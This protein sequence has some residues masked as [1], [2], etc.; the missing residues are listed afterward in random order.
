MSTHIKLLQPRSKYHSLLHRNGANTAKLTNNESPE[1]SNEGGTRPIVDI[2]T[3]FTKHDVTKGKLEYK[4]VHTTLLPTA[5]VTLKSNSGRLIKVRALL[6]QGSQSTFISEKCAQYLKAKRTRLSISV[7]GIGGNSV[8][9]VRS[10]VSFTLVPCDQSKP[11][12]PLSALVLPKLTY[13]PKASYIKNTWPHL[14]N[15]HLAD[16]DFLARYPLSYLLELTFTG[17][18]L[19]LLNRVRHGPD[20]SPTAQLT[21]FGWIISGS[22]TRTAETASLSLVESLDESLRK[23]WEVEEIPAKSIL[24]DEEIKCE[25]YFQSTHFRQSDGTYVI[26]LPFKTELPIPIDPKDELALF[27]LLTLTYGTACAPFVANRVLKQFAVDEGENF[28]L[29]VSVLN[30]YMYVDDV[31]FGADDIVFAKQ[32][33]NQATKLPKAGGFHLCKWA[34]NHVSLLD[35]ISAKNHGLATNTLLKSD[36]NLKVL[37]I[38]WNPTKDFFRF[39]IETEKLDEFTKRS[40]LSM[41]SRMFDPLEEVSNARDY[42]IKSVQTEYYAQELKDLLNKG[43]AAAKSPLFKL[44]P[45]IDKDKII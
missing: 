18:T 20:G 6:A 43:N 31:M 15:L 7:S 13:I 40:Y 17:N 14:E 36:D 5:F 3:H 19:I 32:I 10:A 9:Y 24:S 2:S 4:I 27:R 45:F 8:G 35:D 44:N 25:A 33:R 42:W 30:N 39:H 26:R 21:I 11:E 34:S 38:A 29:A 1:S 23:F 37:G 12:I 22:V 28:S 41:T 16:P